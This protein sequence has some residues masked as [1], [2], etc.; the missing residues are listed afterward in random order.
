M[1]KHPISDERIVSAEQFHAENSGQGANSS[2]VTFRQLGISAKQAK[3]ITIRH[4]NANISGATTEIPG[5]V[6][7]VK[8]ENTIIFSICNVYFEARRVAAQRK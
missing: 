6:V 5:D 7:L 8:N 3:I 1:T 4:G 2:D